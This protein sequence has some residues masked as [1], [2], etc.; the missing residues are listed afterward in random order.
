LSGKYVGIADGAYVGDV[1]YAIYKLVLPLTTDDKID[2]YPA[3]LTDDTYIHVDVLD[4]LDIDKLHVAP[5]S[6]DT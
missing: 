4:V 5:P 3:S 6:V 1:L 2:T